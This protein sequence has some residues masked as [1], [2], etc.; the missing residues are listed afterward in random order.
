MDRRAARQ[1]QR[2]V[3][4]PV[5]RPGESLF[6][7]EKPNGADLEL[8][9]RPAGGVGA[10]QPT[11]TVNKTALSKCLSTFLV[12]LRAPAPTALARQPCPQREVTYL[13]A[14][15]G[16]PNLA[17]RRRCERPAGGA[18][19]SM[20]MRL[21]SADF[22]NPGVAPAALAGRLR[23]R[24]NARDGDRINQS[25]GVSAFDSRKRRRRDSERRSIV[26][27]CWLTDRRSAARRP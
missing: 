6:G 18:P 21:G 9:R 22:A 20:P 25:L 8:P 26:S 27:S 3:S 4:Q 13:G 1:L 11:R 2:L 23:S 5:S 17:Q 7:T 14:L 12:H 16:K 15:D 10:T 19:T 24:G